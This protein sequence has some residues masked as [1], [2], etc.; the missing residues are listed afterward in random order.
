MGCENFK[1]E[2]Y[3]IIS[4]ENNDEQFQK[5][6]KREVYK[7][8]SV[9]NSRELNKI[10]NQDLKMEKEEIEKHELIEDE[11]VGYKIGIKDD[12]DQ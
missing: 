10:L 5:E 11:E 6:F 12:D 9:H 2:L 7:I 1:K 4:S 8:I 3:Q